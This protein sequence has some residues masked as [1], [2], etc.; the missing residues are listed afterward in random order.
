V[1]LPITTAKESIKGIHQKVG[2]EE[3]AMESGD[4]GDRRLCKLER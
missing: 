3:I 4:Y 2:S 1:I